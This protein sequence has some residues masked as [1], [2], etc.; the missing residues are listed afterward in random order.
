M[1]PNAHLSDFKLSMVKILDSI[2]LAAILWISPIG[3]SVSLMDSNNSLG[4]HPLFLR[5][6]GENSELVKQAKVTQTLQL[7]K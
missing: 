7:P 5:S 2:S 3:L 6:P 1:S 4:D